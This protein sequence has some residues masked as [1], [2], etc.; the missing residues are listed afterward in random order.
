MKILF[1]ASFSGIGGAERSLMPLARHLKTQGHE[2]TLF[3]ARPP[4]DAAI[5][6]E[7]AGVVDFPPKK[8]SRLVRL[9]RLARLVSRTDVVIATSELTVTY[10]SWALA[11]IC[12]KPLLADVQVHLSVWIR[13]GCNPVH[14]SLSRWVYRRIRG[15]RCISE[16]VAKDMREEFGVRADRIAIITVPFDLEAIR[17]SGE[18]PVP[19]RDA[20]V[21]MRPVIVGAGRFTSQKRFDVAIRT[22]ESLRRRH[23]IEANLLILGDGEDRDALTQL[24]GSLGLAERVFLP[25]HAV[26]LPTYLRHASAFLLSSDYEGLSRVLIEALTVGCPSV[27][28][29]CPSGPYEVLDGGAAGLLAPCGDADAL[30]D[31]LQRVLTDAPLAEKLRHAGLQRVRMFETSVVA[32]TYGRW[33]QENA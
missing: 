14:L 31:A 13:D 16:G 9:W 33:L 27:S 25:G 30:A 22:L 4:Q 17:T 24:A 7:F 10:V 23:A 12:R 29:D 8:S 26:N 20:A 19:T 2:L 6:E 28:T 5:F 32:Q 11:A 21:F 1:V 18:Q 3:L 15:I